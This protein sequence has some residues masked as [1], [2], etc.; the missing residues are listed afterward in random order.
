MSAAPF[1]GA[2]G[3]LWA[4]GVLIDDL[5]A[6]LLAG[7]REVPGPY[8]RWCLAIDGE[9]VPVVCGDFDMWAE[10]DGPFTGRCGCPL[11][12]NERTCPAHAR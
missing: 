2:Y 5:Q 10:E 3:P 11:H 8:G 9:L 7:A 1:V 4:R 6:A 12:T